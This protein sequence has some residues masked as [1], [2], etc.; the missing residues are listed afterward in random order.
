MKLACF[1]LTLSCLLLTNALTH[2]QE[3]PAP[4]EVS[5]D[6][7]WVFDI[8]EGQKISEDTGKPMFIVFRC[9]R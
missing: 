3:K 8:N 6:I 4:T 1:A 5:G 7:D 2:A 9:E